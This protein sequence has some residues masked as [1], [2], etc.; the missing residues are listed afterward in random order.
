MPLELAILNRKLE[1]A[2]ILVAKGANPIAF[3]VGRNGIRGVIPLMEEYHTFGTN[4]YMKW[5]FHDHLHPSNVDHYIQ[6][7]LE[8]DIFNQ[9]AL[10]MFCQARRHAAHS[11]LTCGHEKLAKA[12]IEHPR[13]GGSELLTERDPAEFTALQIAANNGDLESVKVIMKL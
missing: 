1:V 12:L 4:E 11:L 2:K 10:A 9:V 8:M 7:V 13:H 5:L 6:E 3:P